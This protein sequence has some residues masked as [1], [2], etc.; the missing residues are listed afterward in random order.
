MTTASTHTKGRT[1]RYYRCVR[2]GKQG[3]DTC[4]TRQLPAEAIEGFVVDQLREAIRQGRISIQQVNARLHHL[5]Q[6]KERLALER[7]HKCES[8]DA[9]AAEERLHLDRALIKLE[10]QIQE[11]EWLVTTLGDFEALWEVFTPLNRQRLVRTLVEEV[12]VDE[13]RSEVVVRLADLKH[14]KGEMDGIIG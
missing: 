5:E 12:I 3:S 14:E 7:N 4:N 10:L 11:A 2:R 1:Y 9:Q 13:A 8:A 6:T